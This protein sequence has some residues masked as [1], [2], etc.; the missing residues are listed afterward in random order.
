MVTAIR[1]LANRGWGRKTIARAIGISVNTVRRY[2]GQPI[3][4]GVQGRPA[5][6]R[7]TEAGCA[8]AHAL[9]V[10]RAEGN[11][12]VV[13]RLLTEQGVEVSARTVQRAVAG[14]RRERRAADLATVVAQFP[15]V[16]PFFTLFHP[17]AARSPG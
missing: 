2:L 9:F 12:M 16:P 11:A 10:G 3:V 4:A 14:L 5:A 15:A 7:L 17:V 8:D 13:R 6:R 1:E